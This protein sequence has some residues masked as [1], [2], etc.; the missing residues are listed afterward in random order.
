[1]CW[2]RQSETKLVEISG[3]EQNILNRPACLW[4]LFS[5]SVVSSRASSPSPRQETLRAISCNVKLS[6]RSPGFLTL[7]GFLS[8]SGPCL[9]SHEVLVLAAQYHPLCQGFTSSYSWKHSE[10]SRAAERARLTA[11]GTPGFSAVALKLWVQMLVLLK[12]GPRCWRTFTLAFYIQNQMYVFFIL[13]LLVVC[14]NWC[15]CAIGFVWSQPDW[16]HPMVPIRMFP[17][18]WFVHFVCWRYRVIYVSCFWSEMEGLL[19]QHGWQ[20]YLNT[21]TRQES[22]RWSR[23]RV[24][25]AGFVHPHGSV[26]F[27]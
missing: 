8:F 26:R 16:P 2:N 3:H 14:T 15:A 22:P 23:Q 9:I 20:I 6:Q 25:R 10:V 11:T 1:M 21:L 13:H 19:S 17:L 24:R 12:A 7:L 5:S 27:Q 4:S 18:V